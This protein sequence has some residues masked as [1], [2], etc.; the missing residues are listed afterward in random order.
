MEE[1]MS[2]NSHKH[3]DDDYILRRQFSALVPAFDPRPGRVNVNQTQ[4]IDVVGLASAAAS[5]EAAATSRATAE[6]QGQAASRA[7]SSEFSIPPQPK[8][9][10]MVK[11]TSM[12]G[13][14]WRL[15]ITLSVWHV[16]E[17]LNTG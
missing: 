10:L 14:S 5:A 13:V 16:H 11:S 8:L 17:R 6:G 7:D 3:W 4:D 9:A 1:L 12:P 15:V 2:A